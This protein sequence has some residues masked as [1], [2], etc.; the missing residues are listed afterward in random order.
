MKLYRLFGMHL[1]VAIFQFYPSIRFVFFQA[2]NSQ[3][4]YV[5]KSVSELQIQ[6]ATYVF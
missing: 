1:C 6:V 2:C 4:K 3:F 5:G